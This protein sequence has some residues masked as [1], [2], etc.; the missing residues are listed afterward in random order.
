MAQDLVK[1]D[2]APRRTVG[3]ITAGGAVRPIVPQTYG[4]CIAIAAGIHAAGIAP[5]GLNTPDLLTIAIMAG[6][7][8]GLP[9]MASVQGVMIVNKRPAI[10]GDAAL[11]LVRGSGL[12]EWIEETIEGQG[13]KAVAV[14]RAKRKGEPKPI[15]RRFSVDDAKKAG[16]W[17]SNK[18]PWKKYPLRMLGHRARAWTLRDGFADVLKGL[19]IVE[20]VRDIPAER[21]KLTPPPAPPEEEVEIHS[22]PPADMAERIVAMSRAASADDGP[23]SVP[24]DDPPAV[25]EG[26]EIPENFVEEAAQAMQSAPGDFDIET[27]WIETVLPWQGKIEPPDWAYLEK[28]YKAESK[29][30]AP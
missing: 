15:E 22:T 10:W 14:C 4:E 7:E 28:V 26:G 24:E 20:E 25:E 23:P 12:C 2:D 18:D 13:D 30:R 27:Y 9:P 16:L 6:M 5:E 1:Q 8:A 29:R 17:G 19:H 11:A 3:S 21:E